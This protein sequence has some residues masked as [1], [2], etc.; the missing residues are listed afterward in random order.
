[1]LQVDLV[2]KLPD[3]AGY[4]QILTAKDT[5]SKHLFATPMRNASAPN[6]A[7]QLFHIFMRSTYM[8]NGVLLDMVTAFTSRV[9]TEL[10]R[11]LEIK[12]EYAT[13]N[14]P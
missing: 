14:H 3:S 2:G 13:V 6:V 4:T 7:K 5:F 9:M 11:I 8:P 10:S 1:M 12:L